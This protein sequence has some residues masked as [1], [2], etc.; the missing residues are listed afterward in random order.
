MWFDS[1][2]GFC[3]QVSLGLS[4]RLAGGRSVLCPEDSS[5]QGSGRFSAALLISLVLGA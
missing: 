5:L 4:V 2:D 3:W 1:M